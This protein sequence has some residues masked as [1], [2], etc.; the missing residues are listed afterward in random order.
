MNK[1]EYGEKFNEH[2]LEQYKVFAE[3]LDRISLRRSQM[4]R[5]YASILSGLLV[6][7]SLIVFRGIFTEYHMSIFRIIGIMYNMVFKYKIVCKSF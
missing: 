5:Y 2:L 3:T 4:H 7:L 1:K 6:F